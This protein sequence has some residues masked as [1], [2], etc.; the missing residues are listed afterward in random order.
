MRRVKYCC[1]GEVGRWKGRYG[2][3]G[4][5]TGNDKYPECPLKSL[6]ENSA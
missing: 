4:D 5:T 3:R 1:R 2:G 6:D